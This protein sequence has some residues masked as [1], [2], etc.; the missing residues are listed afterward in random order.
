[1]KKLFLILIIALATCTV[2]E[3]N[4]DDDVILEKSKGKTLPTV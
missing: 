3:E 1:M 2:I 4:F